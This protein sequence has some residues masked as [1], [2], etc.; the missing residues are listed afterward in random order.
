MF[1]KSNAGRTGKWTGLFKLL[2]IVNETYKI[3][4]SSRLSDFKSTVAKPYLIGRKNNDPNNTP[5]TKLDDQKNGHKED[6]QSTASP[7]AANSIFAVVI[8]PP[9]AA[10]LLIGLPDDHNCEA[11]SPLL[12]KKNSN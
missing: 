5:K 11:V 6:H 12:A 1:C 10:D 2:R 3:S 4:L 9:V 8:T 7:I